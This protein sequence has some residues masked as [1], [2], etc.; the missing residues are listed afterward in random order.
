MIQSNYLDPIEKMP[1]GEFIP[2]TDECT[3]SP[4]WRLFSVCTTFSPDQHT[5]H[6]ERI[7][8]LSAIETGLA[9]ICLLINQNIA[10]IAMRR[11]IR[12]Q[13]MIDYDIVS[14]IPGRAGRQSM[15]KDI[16]NGE[17]TVRF[18]MRMNG[19]DDEELDRKLLVRIAVETI[20]NSEYARKHPVSCEIQY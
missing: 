17:Y 13:Y 6:S 12:A 18:T 16:N 11:N 19:D 8:S 10:E 9:E 20:I 14:V 15:P 2:G 4:E 5:D 7:F 1:L 3:E